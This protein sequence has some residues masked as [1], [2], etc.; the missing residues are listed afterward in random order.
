MA[1]TDRLTTLALACLVTTGCLAS[2]GIARANAVADWNDT[3]VSALLAAGHNNVTVTRGLAMVQIAVHDTL[4]A[5]ERR[6]EPYVYDPPA[7]PGASVDAAVATA[8]RDVLV[9]AVP[10]FGTVPQQVT[11]IAAV[12]AAYTAALA[13]IPDEP[14]KASAIAIGRA[15]AAAI[16]ALRKEDGATR[17]TPYTP[18]DGPGHWRPHPNPVPADPPIPSPVLAPGYWPATL[19]GWGAQTPFTLLSG[20]QIPIPGPP[21]LTSEAYARDYEEVKRLGGKNSTVRTAEQSQIARFWYEGSG[22]GW[23]RIARIVAVSRSLDLWDHAQLLALQN[24]AMA[25]G[26]IAGW[27]IRYRH[28]FWRPV[29]AIRAGDTG[30]NPSTVGDRTWESLL[31]TPANPEYPSTHSILGGAAAAVLAAVLGIDEV[32]FSS[33]SGPPFAGLTRSFKSF[34]EAA[35]EN[36]DSRVYAGIHFRSACRD[37]IALRRTIGQ[38]AARMFLQPVR[39]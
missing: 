5:I 27:H 29:T 31:N 3:A 23:N 26:F 22:Q 8:A 35:Q 18:S 1:R 28:D 10:A 37:G 24:T 6:Y 15:A 12:D 38:R 30:G 17:D 11:A 2:A 9:M 16:V 21:A 34:S 25:D 36:A 39:R 19:P 32:A 13:K 14:A 33:T 20:G 7:A 4:N